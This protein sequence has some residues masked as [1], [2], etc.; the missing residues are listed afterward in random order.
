VIK[1]R[2]T[3]RSITEFL[4]LD[5][6]NPITVINERIRRAKTVGE[7]IET[8]SSI[9]RP[10]FTDDRHY[11]YY[12]T[13]VVP[14]IKMVGKSYVQRHPRKD[15]RAYRHSFG[16]EVTLS[17]SYVVLGIMRVIEDLH[18]TDGSFTVTGDR[19]VRWQVYMMGLNSDGRLFVNRVP[20]ALA[21]I[22][23][24]LV[25]YLGV[26]EVREVEDSEI[27]RAMG[28]DRSVDLYD[29]VVI[30]DEGNYRVQ[31]EIVLSENQ[32]WTGSVDSIEDY[33][34]RVAAAMGEEIRN[35]V[36]YLAYDRVMTELLLMGFSAR[37]V[38]RRERDEI[39]IVNALRSGD[40]GDKKAAAVAV[41]LCKRLGGRTYNSGVCTCEVVDS[42]LGSFSVTVDTGEIPYG[43]RYGDIV[44]KV[45][46]RGESRAALELARE[47][48]ERVR[49]M[50]RGVF[51]L[52]LG[53]HLIEV[54]GGY[55]TSV[56]YT[57]SVQPLALPPRL[58]SIAGN[59][60]YVDQGSRVRITHHEHGTI[61]VRF[62]RPFMISFTTTGVDEG[63]PGEVNR[64]ILRRLI[65][66]YEGEVLGL[67]R[68]YVDP[69]TPHLPVVT[70]D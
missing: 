20:P 50:P 13:Y 26:A 25:S 5:S 60:F 58:L 11:A 12:R 35:Y 33:Y 8:L 43:E 47:F 17:N 40:D 27:V 62:A 56:A 14:K 45:Y 65:E 51:K 29:E 32:F 6:P 53:N 68:G 31:G 54:E 38:T 23:G 42:L 3:L 46:A 70:N 39:R 69:Y 48:E 41:A 7:L 15:W 44:I 34:R 18:E 36:R 61:T 22:H 64:V 63:Y 66:E 10:L 19:R 24:N 30:S 2:G 21:G 9:P 1:V 59:A 4:G 28:F 67:A 16:L 55:S 52:M 57:P 49:S 37:F